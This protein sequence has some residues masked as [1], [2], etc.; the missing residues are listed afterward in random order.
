LILL[1]TLTISLK[2]TNTTQSVKYPTILSQMRTLRRMSYMCTPMACAS[3][4]TVTY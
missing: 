4:P 2:T 1:R 3:A